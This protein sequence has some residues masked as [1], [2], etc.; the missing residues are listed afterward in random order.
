MFI[1]ALFV[2]AKNWKQLKYPSRGEWIN[3]LWC[4]H[5]IN[6]LKNELLQHTISWMNLRRIMLGKRSQM[7]LYKNEYILYGSIY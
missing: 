1:A 5:L 3:A 2:V 4:I 6:D 7:P